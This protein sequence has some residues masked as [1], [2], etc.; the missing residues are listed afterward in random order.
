MS[1]LDGKWG[2]AATSMLAQQGL[3]PTTQGGHFVIIEA[4]SEQFGSIP[5]LKSLDRIRRRRNESEYPGPSNYAAIEIDEVVDAIEVAE[6]CIS[7]AGKL[8]EA[9]ELGVF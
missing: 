9:G 5:G 7:S 3:R 2:E 4:M 1:W 6:S 8:I